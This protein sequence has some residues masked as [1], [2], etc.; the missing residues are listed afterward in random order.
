MLLNKNNLILIQSQAKSNGAG[1]PSHVE[2]GKVFFLLTV[3]KVHFF[4]P[5]IT[6]ET[7]GCIYT[8]NFQYNLPFR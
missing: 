5:C 2:K 8:Q 4:Q 3:G 1:I 7:A 6:Q